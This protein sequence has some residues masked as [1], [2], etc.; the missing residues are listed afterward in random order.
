MELI[1][2]A[3]S[4]LLK[5]KKTTINN[6]IHLFCHCY[7]AK[8]VG[9]SAVYLKDSYQIRFSDLRLNSHPM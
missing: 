5:K 4:I 3:F 1:D 2:G 9:V 6:N 7:A 8:P